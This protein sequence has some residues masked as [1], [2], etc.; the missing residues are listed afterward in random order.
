MSPGGPGEA[1]LPSPWGALDS[2]DPVG[3]DRDGVVVV[4]AAIRARREE[5]HAEVP[6]GEFGSWRDR[7]L[8]L[9]EQI[10]CLHH[11]VKTVGGARAPVSRGA[12]GRRGREIRR[13][14]PPCSAGEWSFLLAFGA[15]LA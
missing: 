3:R 14:A 13:E 4:I 5:L 8:K 1:G 7:Y 10:T 6:V 12:T 2:G 15:R 9:R 11:S